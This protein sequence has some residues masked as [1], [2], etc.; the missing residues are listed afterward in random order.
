[1]QGLITC[2]FL[3]CLVSCTHKVELITH[4]QTC[5]QPGM[6]YNVLLPCDLDKCK[7]KGKTFK[8]VKNYATHMH[9]FHYLAVDQ[10]GGFHSFSNDIG[11][12]VC[13]NGNFSTGVGFNYPCKHFRFCYDDFRCQALRRQRD[14][15]VCVE[16]NEPIWFTVKLNVNKIKDM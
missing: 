9:K 10:F 8:S 6:V 7:G 4:V 1:M 2:P 11:C 14:P 15:N 3:G 16:C 13:A 12:I 5:H